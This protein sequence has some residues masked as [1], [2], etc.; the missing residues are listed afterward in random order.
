MRLSLWPLAW[1]VGIALGAGLALRLGAY[2]PAWGAALAFPA[3]AV[4]FAIGSW[5]ERE[6]ESITHLLR[7]TLGFTLGFLCATLPSTVARLS[8]LG[9]AA[10]G[11]NGADL[12][13]ELARLRGELVVRW[14]VIALALPVGI[15]ALWLRRDRA[16]H[17]SSTDAL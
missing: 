7:L 1:A 15:T 16:R 14:S 10:S 17:A 3:V 5:K 8:E 6:G 9:D 13:A 11:E 4:I 2:G 12:A